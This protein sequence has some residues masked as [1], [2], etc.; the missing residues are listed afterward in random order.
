MF[1][2][3]TREKGIRISTLTIIMLVLTLIFG[4]MMLISSIMLGSKYETLLE[5]DE[6]YKSCQYRTKQMTDATN[7]MA[8]NVQY[9]VQTYNVDYMTSYI[10]EYNLG[11]REKAVD[12][13]SSSSEEKYLI[14][15]KQNS[16][17]L[18]EKDIHIMKL[19]VRAQNIESRYVP[20]KIRQFELPENERYMS[21]SAKTDLAEN[22]LYSRD[23]ND[24]R[25]RMITNINEY[26]NRVLNRENSKLQENEDDMRTHI[27]YQQ[28]LCIAV[29]VVIIF[30]GILLYKMVINVLYNY[31]KFILNNSPLTPAGVFELR[32]LADAYNENWEKKEKNEQRL[33]RQAK[34]DALT[35]IFNRGALEQ[36]VRDR[37]QEEE[38]NGAFILIDVDKFKSVNDGYGHEMGDK[39]LKLVAYMLVHSFR[40]GDVVGRLGGDEFAIWISHLPEE[41]LHYITERFEVINK[42]LTSPDVSFPSISLSVGITLCQEGDDFK[43]VYN[44][45]DKALYYVKE[46]GRCGYRVYGEE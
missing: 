24:T 41:H 22:M 39:V 1:S 9:F 6:L 17:D 12:G 27:Q 32:Y 11:R 31:V 44:R 7:N 33:T 26:S 21:S 29:I 34:Y 40:K 15:A 3:K 4:S 23:Y 35:G 16:D 25:T 14:K 19:V 20:L 42:Q 46:H 2:K 28:I 30:I 5:S 43:S 38:W 10:R 36:Y 37:L 45:A 18:V 13:L 8:L